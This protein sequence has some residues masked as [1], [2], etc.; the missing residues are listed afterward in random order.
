MGSDG[1]S[2]VLPGACCAVVSVA[3]ALDGELSDKLAVAIGAEPVDAVLADTGVVR[4][5]F[6]GS[7]F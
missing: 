1:R 2:A 6:D 4:A 7:R 3:G 5:P